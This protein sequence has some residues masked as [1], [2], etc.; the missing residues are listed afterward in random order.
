MLFLGILTRLEQEFDEEI[1]EEFTNHLGI[2][3]NSI[4]FAV[5][6]M[7]RKDLYKDGVNELF[8]IFHSLK[9]ASAF[10]KIRDIHRL[11]VLV[12]DVLSLAR[13]LKGPA[14]VEFISWIRALHAQMD[15]WVMDLEED[16]ERLSPFNADVTEIPNNLEK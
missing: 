1:V 2:M 8:R 13:E 5:V 9:S 4:R 14:S 10:L 12:E 11:A 16:A 3:S 15:L 6:K 7:Q